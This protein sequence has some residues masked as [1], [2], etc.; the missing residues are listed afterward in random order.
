MATMRS[1]RQEDRKPV[2]QIARQPGTVLAAAV[3]TYVRSVFLTLDSLR[4]APALISD[5]PV[6]GTDFALQVFVFVAIPVAFG[7]ASVALAALAQRRRN[8]ARVA[9]TVV[10][11]TALALSIP[12]DGPEL[13][14]FGHAA[15]VV[16]VLALLWAPR[17]N[18]WYRDEPKE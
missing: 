10:S 8:G 13:D 12:T 17:S 18:A 4:V 2:S 3:M 5:D 14:Y 16:V 15:Y 1:P 11:V 9:L 7:G 6:N